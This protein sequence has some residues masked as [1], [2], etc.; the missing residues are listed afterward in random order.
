[1]FIKMSKKNPVMLDIIHKKILEIRTYPYHEYKF[2]H[3]PLEGYN[4]IHIDKHFVLVFRI[5][6]AGECVYINRFGHHDYIYK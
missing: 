3:K 2:L 1:M 6:H 5:D 4:R